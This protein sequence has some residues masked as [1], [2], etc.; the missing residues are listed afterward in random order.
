MQSFKM[1]FTVIFI[2]L[3]SIA[4]GANHFCWSVDRIADEVI[5]HTDTNGDGILSSGELKAELISEWDL[6]NTSCLSYHEFTAN[7][8]LKFHDHHDTAHAFFNTL[9]TSKDKQLC[10]NEVT[11]HIGQYDTNPSRVQF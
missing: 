1:K 11:A 3:I 6:S 9:D 7:W 8:V 4:Y 2:A 5:K 10:E